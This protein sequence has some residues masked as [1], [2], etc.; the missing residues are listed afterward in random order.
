[1]KLS[2]N[3]LSPTIESPFDALFESAFGDIDR[4]FS[5]PTSN[6]NE[7]AADL[8]EGHDGFT[9]RIELPGATRD[10]IS[11]NVEDGVLTIDQYSGETRRTRAFDLNH[12]VD[13]QAIT[14]SLDAGILTLTLP[15]SDASK[16]HHVA[17]D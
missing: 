14:A 5:R 6:P 7:P 13:H 2:R 16:P 3:T 9:I 17:I 11:I 4:L 12:T 1:M 10:D 15:R 8:L